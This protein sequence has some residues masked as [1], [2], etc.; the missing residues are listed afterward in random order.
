M[1]YSVEIELEEDAPCSCGMCPWVGPASE[2][3]EIKGCSLTPGDPSPAGRC[4]A[5]DSLAYVAD[6]KSTPEVPESATDAAT[7]EHDAAMQADLASALQVVLDLSTAHMP[8]SSPPWGDLR[9]VE[10]EHGY[11]VFVSSEPQGREPQ[12]A[13]KVLALARKH[14][15]L[16]VNF[17]QDG[18]E[19][20][21]HL[22]MWNWDADT[23][24]VSIPD[25]SGKGS[26][27]RSYGTFK[28]R[29]EA[30][31]F[32]QREFGADI[33]GKIDAITVRRSE[34]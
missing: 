11:V 24:E 19:L 26:A 20:P 25:T 9:V 23:Y 21:E 30:I 3:A 28:T 14:D 8:G 2:L 10:H 4:P 6:R 27:Y 12:W 33:F 34:C 1:R 16:L 32:A 15:C 22:P 17:D 18:E 29:A 7:R 5:C 31:A 13:T